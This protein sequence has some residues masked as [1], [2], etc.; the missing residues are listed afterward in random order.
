M[1]KSVV[2]PVVT[3]TGFVYYNYRNQFWNRSPSNLPQK[4][5]P[6]DL[7]VTNLK[8][9]TT[10][11]YDDPGNTL[12]GLAY[13]VEPLWSNNA[14]RSH[15]DG[16]VINASNRAYAAFRGA[17]RA[18]DAGLGVTL[19][20]YK[21]TWDMIALRCNTI[22]SLAKQ[23][24]ATAKARN[25]A[26]KR[27]KAENRRATRRGI[28]Q[29]WQ[30]KDLLPTGSANVFLE[31]LFGWSPLIGS[32]VDSAKILASDPPYQRVSRTIT[33]SKRFPNTTL[34]DA[35]ISQQDC[36]G[37][38]RVCQSAMV[39]ISNPNAWLANQAGLINPAVVAWD[40]VPWSFVVNMFVNVNSLLNSYT[41]FYG[42]EVTDGSTT[43]RCDYHETS[44]LRKV[45]W[46]R[47]YIEDTR[48]FN[49]Y[50]KVRT[51]GLTAPRLEFK[52]PPLTVTSALMAASLMV[53][54]IS[55]LKFIRS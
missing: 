37:T 45:L 24:E 44:V 47:Y 23:A 19:A 12:G 53:Q 41:D 33:S 31:G 18:G 39:R 9:R 3:N 52:L 7:L 2:Q 42:L 48:V 17:L 22:R 40:L 8:L 25:K 38:A 43:I 35:I 34:G 15:M 51:I 21:Q 20:S 32:I 14:Y 50:T 13:S 55:G 30:P 1:F 5:N 36:F 26:V 54:Q 46:V 27:R 11:N 28:K 6:M 29:P 10:R 16:L 4:A 49:N